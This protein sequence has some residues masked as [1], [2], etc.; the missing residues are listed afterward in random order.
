MDNTIIYG[1]GAI[2]SNPDIKGRPVKVLSVRGP[3]TRDV[4]IKNG[5][6]CPAVY[7]DPALLLP[8]VYKPQIKNNERIGI[9]P[10]IEH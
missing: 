5:I 7:G 4:L 2:T 1:S 8:L 6:D 10:I 3:L 9:I